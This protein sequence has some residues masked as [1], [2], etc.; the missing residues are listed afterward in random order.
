[1]TFVESESWHD[2][3]VSCLMTQA[4]I[5][6]LK[7]ISVTT[8]ISSPYRTTTDC[9]CSSLGFLSGFN[10]SLHSE[11]DGRCSV[12]AEV[13]SKIV[14]GKETSEQASLFAEFRQNFAQNIF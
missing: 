2:G 14:L 12:V 9:H 6:L 13:I 11:F 10:G 3:K 1:M 7:S 8:H 4:R 5:G